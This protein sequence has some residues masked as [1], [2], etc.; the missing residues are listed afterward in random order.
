MRSH[1]ISEQVFNHALRHVTPFASEGGHT[2]VAVPT[3]PLT[4]QAWPL[5]SAHF[6][7]WLGNSFHAEYGIFAG[8]QALRHVVSIIQARARF[9]PQPA[10]PDVFTR[11]GWRGDPLR[12]DALTIDLANS[13]REAIEITPS[14]WH[15]TDAD[16]WRFRPSPA[17]RP[18]PRP[19]SAS[20]TPGLLDSLA[21]LL[22]ALPTPTLNRLIT[23]LFSSLRPTGPYPILI[24]SGPPASGKSITARIL[25]SLIDPATF[26]LLALPQS[27]R[28]LFVLALHNRILLFDHVPSLNPDLSVALARLAAGTAFTHMSHNPFDTPLPLA[29]QRPVILTVP[30][31]EAAA[32]HWSRNHTVSSL[33]ITAQFETIQPSRRRSHHDIADEFARALPGILAALCNAVSMALGKAAETNVTMPSRFADAQQW[34]ASAAPAL[35]LSIED[36]NAALGATPLV[37][38][39][40]GLLAESGTWTGSPTDLLTALHG[41]PALPTSAKG[42]TQALGSTP[43]AVFGINYSVDRKMDQRRITLSMT[44]ATKNLSYLVH[45]SVMDSM[46]S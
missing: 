1:S 22:P 32:A 9:A 18:L 4:H 16:G 28:E 23:W 29:V 26:P 21:P 15:V 39:L 8:D 27:E 33:A 40:T 5:A 46:E 12:P 7:T 36:V 43:L 30:S 35:G 19:A 34:T 10:E 3:G 31:T 37:R 42:L 25:R 6:R 38:A 41:I 24:L 20:Q 44:D 14:G 13:A 17:S 11:I 45:T 2:W